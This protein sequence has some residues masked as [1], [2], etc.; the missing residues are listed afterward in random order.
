[1]TN[2]TKNPGLGFALHASP[3]TRAGGQ[4][5]MK[6]SSVL[7]NLAAFLLLAVYGPAFELFGQFRYVEVVLLT[8]LFIN[9]Y[10]VRHYVD[11]ISIILT[12]LFILTAVSQVMSDIFN[13]VY[14][15]ST[16]KRVGT[17][18]IF[19]AIFLACKLLSLSEWPRLRWILAGYSLSWIF[20]YFVGTS[21]AE[22]YESIPW[23]L[24]LGWAFTLF[25]CLLM[26]LLPRLYLV[27]L[28]ILL[29]VA[30]LHII[31]DSRSIALFTLFVFAASAYA[32]I[33]G[34][35]IAAKVTGRRFLTFFGILL[36][37]TGIGYYSIIFA[38]ENRLLPVE[39]QARTE[40][41]VYSQYGLAATARPET[42]ASLSA[43]AERPL[44][45]WGSTAYDPIIW[46]Y[47]TDLLTANWSN[48]VDFDNIYQD[49]FHQEWEGGMPSHSHYFGAWVDGGFLASL[50]W[51]AVLIISLLAIM[52]CL[53][54]RHPIVPI[55]FF[56]ASTTIW[57][58]LFSP[59]PHRMDMALRLTLLT[60]I[61]SFVADTHAI[62]V[63]SDRAH[64]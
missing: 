1:M 54:W 18:V 63:Q 27:S 40:V 10:R 56:V 26:S 19:I 49:T 48:R 15:G 62:K 20:I 35:P 34:K 21:A 32:A 22:N 42:A 6:R 33:F 5:L 12:A 38:T 2:V 64:S 52:Q 50:S 24:G 3:A 30:A 9:A 59:G 46:H 17:Y 36:L 57:D 4:A 58:V 14:A 53:T 55:V 41:Q 23:R 43:I 61:L 13:G 7:S 31:L 44:L 47:Y 16:I 37:I 28:S 11:R 25:L 39:I 29:P 45:G 60:F 8:F 51:L